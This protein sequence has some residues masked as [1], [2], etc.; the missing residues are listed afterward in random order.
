[1]G[2]GEVSALADECQVLNKEEVVSPKCKFLAS[3]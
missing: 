2:R 1:M 3:P